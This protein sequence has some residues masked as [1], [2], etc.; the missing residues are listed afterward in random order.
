MASKGNA[1]WILTIFIWSTVIASYGIGI[2]AWGVILPVALIY[3]RSVHKEREKKNHD[4]SD[5]TAALKQSLSADWTYKAMKYNF[6][7]VGGICVILIVYLISSPKPLEEGHIK[8]EKEKTDT[9]TDTK[10]Y[11]S[12]ASKVDK[13][14][15]DKISVVGLKKGSRDRLVAIKDNNKM[16]FALSFCP[17]CSSSEKAEIMTCYELGYDHGYYGR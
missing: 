11:Y 4:P 13:E 2:L 14:T 7:L 16:D 3:K 15:C 10:Q 12:W 8:I 1:W 5:F 9:K 6:M 17:G